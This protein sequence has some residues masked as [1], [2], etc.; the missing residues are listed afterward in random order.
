MHLLRC[1]FFFEARFSCK[2]SAVHI[3]GVLNDRAD[4]LSRNRLSSFFS[5][6]L[7]ADRFSTPIPASLLH[8]LESSTLDWTSQAWRQQF[9]AYVQQA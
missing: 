5:K 2:L 8:L 7:G 1:M 3:S 4:D 6:V 9:T